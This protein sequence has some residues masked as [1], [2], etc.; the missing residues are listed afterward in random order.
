MNPIVRPT[1]CRDPR[2]EPEDKSFALYRAVMCYS[3]SG[4]NDC[5]G[6]EVEPAQRKAWFNQLKTDYRG[7]PWAQ[8]LKYYW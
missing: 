7:G 2:A 6:K 8:R 1:I 5:G 3:P 4:Y